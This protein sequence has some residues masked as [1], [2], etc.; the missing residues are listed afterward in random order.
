MGFFRL[1]VAK[2]VLQVAVSGR[3]FIITSVAK[4]C[5]CFF[6]GFAFEKKS[7]F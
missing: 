6:N 5:H 2:I 3:S 4:L 7:R 1:E